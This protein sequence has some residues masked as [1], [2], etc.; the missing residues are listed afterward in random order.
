M[1]GPQFQSWLRSM[2]RKNIIN[3]DRDA[4]R[5]LGIHRNTIGRF[6]IEG[7]KTRT[8]DLACRA[9]LDERAPY[10]EFVDG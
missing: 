1:T 9:L 8:I 6:K 10:G 5:L 3:E 7:T 4:A 2:R